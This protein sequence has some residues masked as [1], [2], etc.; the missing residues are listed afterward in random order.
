[1][2]KKDM[3]QGDKIM[4]DVSAEEYRRRQEQN[5][6]DDFIVGDDGYKDHGG[7]IWDYDDDAYVRKGK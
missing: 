1:M 3:E 6:A 5:Q 2:D 7:E 4:E